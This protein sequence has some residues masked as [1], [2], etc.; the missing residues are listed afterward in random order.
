M[1][2]KETT[3]KKNVCQKFCNQRDRNGDENPK[4]CQTDKTRKQRCEISP[5]SCKEI[6]RHVDL[7]VTESDAGIH[8]KSPLMVQNS[9]CVVKCCIFIHVILSV[10]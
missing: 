4:L 10:V 1:Q 8:T 9:H 3:W 5:E 7:S 2:H 6:W